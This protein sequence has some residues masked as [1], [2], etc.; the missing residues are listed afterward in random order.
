MT[1]L[2]VN[3]IL[4]VKTPIVF[5]IQLLLKSKKNRS[6]GCKI[7][8]IIIF[9]YLLVH[10]LFIEKLLKQKKVLDQIANHTKTDILLQ[11]I[12]IH[13]CFGQN[14]ENFLFKNRDVYKE[15]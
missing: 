12:L 10:I 9:S 14:L 11:Q 8:I 7:V 3:R 15:R 1:L 2:E 5:L 4:L 13:F 6:T